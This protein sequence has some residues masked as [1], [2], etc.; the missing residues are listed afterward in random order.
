MLHVLKNVVNFKVAYKYKMTLGKF[1]YVLVSAPSHQNVNE[2]MLTFQKLHYLG[3]CYVVQLTYFFKSTTDRHYACHYFI[4]R[5]IPYFTVDNAHLMCTA[6]SVYSLSDGLVVLIPHTLCTLRTWKYIACNI[7]I[8]VSKSFWRYFNAR[9]RWS[10]RDNFRK[11]TQWC[12]RRDYK[13][14]SFIWLWFRWRFC[15]FW[16]TSLYCF[17]TMNDILCFTLYFCIVTWNTC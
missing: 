13:C 5:V 11:W 7:S 17:H 12:T 16:A 8:S 9:N 4:M 14:T 2:N 10:R 6:H 15:W 1:S 3:W